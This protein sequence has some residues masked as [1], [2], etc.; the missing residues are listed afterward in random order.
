MTLILQGG[1]WTNKHPHLTS[2]FPPFSCW[3]PHGPNMTR[4]QRAR[5]PVG[6]IQ[7]GQCPQ[8]EEVEKG[9]ASGWRV[10]WKTLGMSL[11]FAWYSAFTKHLHTLLVLTPQRCVAGR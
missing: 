2:T 5:E 6:A 4:S 3:G 1:S 8:V 7:A 11:K 10:Q 9:Q